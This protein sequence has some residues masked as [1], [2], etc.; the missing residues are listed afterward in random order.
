MRTKLG[1]LSAAS[2][3]AAAAWTFWGTLEGA[4]LDR[5]ASSILSDRSGIAVRLSGCRL[6]RLRMLSF[7]SAQLGLDNGQGPM[8]ATGP[9][10]ARLGRSARIRLS[11]VKCR[12]LG[13][14]L[15]S[16]G[17]SAGMATISDAE[18]VVLDRG[19]SRLVRILRCDI[20]GLRINGSVRLDRG[21]VSR[22]A[23]ALRSSGDVWERLPDAWQRR[24]LGYQ[25]GERGLRV[26]LAS[27]NARLIGRN[28]PLI[29]FGWHAA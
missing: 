20:P 8:L 1:L 21:I 11:N 2:L 12:A 4:W 3:L 18:L 29:E 22:S 7:E 14:L 6:T 27:D 15:D 28:G 25:R 9:G 10:N 13:S 26:Q 24:L 5:A 19:G 17:L 23:L 16:V